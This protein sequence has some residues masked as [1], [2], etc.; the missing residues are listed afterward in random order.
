LENFNSFFKKT[1]VN[2]STIAG[3]QTLSRSGRGTF[4][5]PP[6]ARRAREKHRKTLLQHQL[7]LI[8]DFAFVLH[9]KGHNFEDGDALKL[10]E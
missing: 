9:S 6:F 10:S 4:P 8:A 2:L 3:L 5:C 1:L 7:C